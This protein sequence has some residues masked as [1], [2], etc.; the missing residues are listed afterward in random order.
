MFLFSMHA[1]ALPGC[2]VPVPFPCMWQAIDYVS[3]FSLTT[4]FRYPYASYGSHV[5][6]QCNG[7]LL[8][9]TLPGQEVQV[10]G[11]A[12]PVLPRNSR[13]AL[14]QVRGYDQ[15]QGQ[16]DSADAGDLLSR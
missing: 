14:M 9:L 3:G 2:T 4:A 16:Q 15:Q 7:T 10:V 11:P 1:A 13:T 6:G 8:S 12:V 5:S